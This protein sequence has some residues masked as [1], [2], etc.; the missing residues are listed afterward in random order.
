MDTSYALYRVYQ[1]R[2]GPRFFTVEG[3][4]IISELQLTPVTYKAIPTRHS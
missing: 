2:D 1:V 4:D 3:G